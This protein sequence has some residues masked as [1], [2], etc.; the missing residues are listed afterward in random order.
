[1]YNSN[2]S[3]VLSACFLSLFFLFLFTFKYVPTMY[4]CSWHACQ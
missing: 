3:A 4:H 1:L 2:S